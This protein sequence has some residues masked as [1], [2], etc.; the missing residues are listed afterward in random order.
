MR[1]M[2]NNKISSLSRHRKLFLSIF[3]TIL[4]TQG[5]G[6]A[7]FITIP[8]EE[9]E[10]DYQN[11]SNY[12]DEYDLD[13][14]YISYTE[15]DDPEDENNTY[16][17]I[18]AP[19]QA[20]KNKVQ[21]ALEIKVGYFFFS[22]H[23]MQ[24]IYDRG[25]LD[26]QAS[27]SYPMWR[28]LQIYGSVEYLEKHGR[29]LNAYQ[30]TR[31]REVPLSLGLKPIIRLSPKVEYYF[32]LGPRYIF[33]CQH[34]HSSFVDKKIRQSGLGGF[35]NTGFNFHINPHLLIDV[36]GEYS[37]KQMHFHSS[38]TNVYGRNIQVGGFTFGAGLGYA[39]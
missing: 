29:S 24:K 26:V 2:S 37:Y 30:K 16:Q 8:Y 4:S 36:F 21:P 39:F 33:V 20:R 34:N 14:Q 32:T 23:K 13:D 27:I 11:N 35:V 9:Q 17:T 12:D 38:K 31:I 1:S 6:R 18:S 25:G 15:E 3:L 22:D 28:W 10:T 5:F 19:P 7:K